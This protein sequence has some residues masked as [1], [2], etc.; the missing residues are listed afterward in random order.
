[1]NYTNPIISPPLTPPLS[2]VSWTRFASISGK[3]GS[4]DLG[5]CTVK[6]DEDFVEKGMYVSIASAPLAAEGITSIGKVNTFTASLGI[7]P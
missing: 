1:M 7:G 5:I 4:V 2:P 6:A 3:E